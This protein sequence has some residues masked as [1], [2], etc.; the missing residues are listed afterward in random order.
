MQ[1]RIFE[2]ELQGAVSY[3]H[4]DVYKRQSWERGA[5]SRATSSVNFAAPN[6]ASKPL[7]RL[8]KMKPPTRSDDMDDLLVRARSARLLALALARYTVAPL[9]VSDCVNTDGI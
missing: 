2:T 8:G 7:C 1:K 4:L 5:A 6:M 9:A 3:T